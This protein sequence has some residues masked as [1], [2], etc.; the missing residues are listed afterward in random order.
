[1]QAWILGLTLLASSVFASQRRSFPTQF[2]L[3]DVNGKDYVSA[4][5]NQNGGTCWTHGAMAALE[6]NLIVTG[7]WD[8]ANESGEP[9]LAEYHLDWWNGFNQHYN[10]DTSPTSNGLTVHEGGD[11]RVAAAYLSRGGAVRDLDG[12]SYSSAP[13]Q[14]DPGFHSYYARDIEWL[15][16]GPNLES[17]DDIKLA[18]MENGVVGTALDWDSSFY[19]TSKNTFYQ[20]PTSKTSPNHAVAIAGWD[21]TKKTQAPKPGAWLIKNSWGTS[22][23]E[24]GFFWISYYD[25]TSGHHA[26][27]GAVAFKN[28]E[29]LQYRQIYSRDYHGWRATKAST[30]EAFNAFTA[31][32]NGAGQENL[33]AVSFY[34]TSDNVQYAAKVFLTYDG[35]DL[36]DQVSYKEG[37]V[38]HKGF[39]TVDLEWP[40]S[41][42]AGT[43]FYVYLNVS[44]GGQAYDHTSDV[45]VLLGGGTR[46]IVTSKAALG[47]SFFKTSTGWSD[48]NQTDKTANFCIKGLSVFE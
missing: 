32:G 35:T 47:E 13:K 2:D 16:A 21:D 41:L 14:T 19:S 11:Y 12:Q 45:P 8:A 7:A 38:D 4:V 23:G 42:K 31:V 24:D 5:K 34:T 10:A 39:H 1:M 37:V 28:V 33:K 18:L 30:P 20:P 36:K 9:N 29:R 48:L 26:D 3:R 43:K 25:K 44:D 6:S 46:T 40:V 22:W 27:M 17:I 15:T